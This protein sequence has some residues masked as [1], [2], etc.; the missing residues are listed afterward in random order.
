MYKSDKA[1]EHL[2]HLIVEEGRNLP[3]MIRDLRYTTIRLAVDSGPTLCGSLNPIGISYTN[4]WSFYKLRLFKF[5]N[6]LPDRRQK[7]MPKNKRVE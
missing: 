7:A 5:E 1:L 6:G 3:Q 4:Y 2:A